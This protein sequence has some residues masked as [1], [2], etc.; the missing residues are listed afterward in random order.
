MQSDAC[1]PNDRDGRG[2]AAGRLS[3]GDLRSRYPDSPTGC[4]E[5]RR[6]IPRATLELLRRRRVAID[7]LELG[8]RGT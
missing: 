6:D 3:V 8:R 4:A 2:L 5:S 7:Q 1:C